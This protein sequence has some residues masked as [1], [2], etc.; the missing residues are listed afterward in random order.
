MERLS[1]HGAWRKGTFRISNFGLRISDLKTRRQGSG[2]R[3]Q[4]A[5]DS[6]CK[7]HDSKMQVSRCKMHDARGILLNR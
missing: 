1:E 4:R 5:K 6:G 7:I 3:D 2:I